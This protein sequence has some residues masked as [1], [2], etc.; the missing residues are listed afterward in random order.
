MYGI[1]KRAPKGQEWNENRPEGRSVCFSLLPSDQTVLETF[2][3]KSRKVAMSPA[4]SLFFYRKA[5]I[6][7]C[8]QAQLYVLKPRMIVEQRERALGCPE[9][10]VK[11]SLFFFCP[12]VSNLGFF[13]CEC[14]LRSRTANHRSFGKSYREQ[15]CPI[16][17][18]PKKE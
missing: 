9:I 15:G 12:S 14:W 18:L 10:G 1:S 7:I 11:W 5:R 16:P 6:L 13:C 17:K 8:D 4:Q 2:I 3:S